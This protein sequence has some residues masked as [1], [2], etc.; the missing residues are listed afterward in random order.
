MSLVL[1]FLHPKGGVGK[2]TVALCLAAALYE[3]GESVR[4][5][6]TD[7]Q[8]TALAHFQARDESPPLVEST[9]SA[10]EVEEALAGAEEDVVLIDGSARMKGATGR[11]VAL[12]DMVLIPVQPSPADVWAARSMAELVKRRQKETGD[13]AAGFVL[14]RVTAGTRLGKETT[15][16]LEDLGFPVVA[17][18]HRRVAYAEALV[19][20]ETPTTYEPEGKAAGEI[21][22][23][24]EATLD[25]LSTHY[26]TTYA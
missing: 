7:P 25:A 10:E 2:S 13:P 17:K 26:Q 16:V 4:V 15:E 5:L 3:N 11:L 1:S 24:L 23:L 18:L 19:T 9:P 20:G 6:D 21:S 12:S 22:D 14:N 8:G